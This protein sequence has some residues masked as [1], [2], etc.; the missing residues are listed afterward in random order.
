MNHAFMVSIFRKIQTKA[1]DTDGYIL[2]DK[3]NL[4]KNKEKILRLDNRN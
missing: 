1:T 3:R 4:H 2:Y